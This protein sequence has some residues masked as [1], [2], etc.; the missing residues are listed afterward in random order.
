MSTLPSG[1]IT[2]PVVS[3]AATQTTIFATDAHATLQVS[4]EDST[5]AFWREV[6]G[7]QG[8]RSAPIVAK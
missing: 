6:P 7:L 2:A 1:N 8:M 5:S 4:S 3:V